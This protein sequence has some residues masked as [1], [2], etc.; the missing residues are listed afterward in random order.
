MKSNSESNSEKECDEDELF[1]EL[2]PCTSNTP[3]NF[4]ITK[5]KFEIIDLCEIF[6]HKY[7]KYAV[8]IAQ[9]AF[10]FT[11][12]WSDATVAGTAWA[13]K[14]PF[15]LISSYLTCP[16]KAFQHHTLPSGGCLYTYYLSV[17]LYACVV[18]SLSL[19]D[20]KEQAF[21][22]LLF[23]LMRFTTISIIALFCI[24]QLFQDVDI[25]LIT[26][27]DYNSTYPTIASNLELSS[28]VVKFDVFGWLQSIPIFTFGYMFLV[29]IPAFV[30]PIQQKKSL[31]W[32]LV[33]VVASVFMSYLLIGVAGSL[34]LR[35][36]VQENCTLNWVSSA[37]SNFQL[38]LCLLY[39][40]CFL[41]GCLYRSQPL[42]ANAYTFILYCTVPIP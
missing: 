39:I 24:V 32:L 15:H 33:A 5:R 3:P 10:M 28:I 36:A 40:F 9:T 23:G 11:G 25:C 12:I 19:L 26:G 14:V 8:F 16:D 17:T 18:I 22:Q 41:L 29:S 38:L 42:D 27:S 34:W 35:A 7:F 30:H 6:F 31:H 1:S 2:I 13:T 4:E 20:L 21:F 37:L